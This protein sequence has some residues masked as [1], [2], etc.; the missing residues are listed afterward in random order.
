MVILDLALSSAP[1]QKNPSD[2]TRRNIV[3]Q[4]VV[5]LINVEEFKRRL[6]SIQI[7]SE[8]AKCWSSVSHS[9]V[10]WY[11]SDMQFLTER[12]MTLKLKCANARLSNHNKVFVCNSL[13]DR[14]AKAIT[15]SVNFKLNK[16][17]AV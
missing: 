6:R 2:S 1:Q 11:P 9:A 10:L 4:V 16:V 3:V 15:L 8:H 17:C 14:D 12:R 7:D 13:Y 5:D